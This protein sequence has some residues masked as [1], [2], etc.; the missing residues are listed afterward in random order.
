MASSYTRWVERLNQQMVLRTEVGRR[1]IGTIGVL[2]DQ[3]ADSFVQS[4]RASWVGDRAEVGPAYDALTP[5]GEELSL[6]RYPQETWTQ[7]HTRLQRAWN[8]WPYAGH[9][10]SILGQLTAAGYDGA[11]IFYTDDMT[12]WSHFWVFFPVGTH[13]VTSEGPEIGSFVVGDGTTIGPEGLD[14]IDLLTTRLIIKKF[15]PAHWVCDHIIYEIE[16]WTVGSGHLVGEL[17]LVIGGTRAK[18]GVP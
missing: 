5:A 7:Y 2:I 6:P 1:F 13:T 14:A 9:E 18:V 10:S 8:D 3:L 17:D 15:K 12:D 16:G 4:V 11:Q